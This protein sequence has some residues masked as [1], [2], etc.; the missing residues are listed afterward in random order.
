VS[1]MTINQFPPT[2]HYK[3]ARRY[4]LA[5]LAMIAAL[6]LRQLLAPLLGETNP[7]HTLWP[8]VVFSAWYCGLGPSIV[9]TL[10]GLI[11]VWYWFLPPYH[12]F[13]LDDPKAEI[14]GM[15]GFLIFSAIII[16]LGESNRRSLFKSKW[17]EEQLQRRHDEL[18]RKVQER[19]ADLKMANDSLR[20][21]S[22][23]L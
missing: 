20:E 13:R 8:A 6:W 7:Y 18:D 17:A 15:L 9:T 11:G 3:D 10:T 12:S 4:G 22:G 19:T 21:L 2:G 16:A 1:Q 23:R 14:Y 5:V